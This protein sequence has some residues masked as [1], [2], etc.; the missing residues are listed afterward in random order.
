MARIQVWSTPIASGVRRKPFS[1]Q[2]GL[3]FPAHTAIA[4][5]SN[6]TGALFH[7]PILLAQAKDFLQVR[8][9]Q[10]YYH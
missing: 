3:P 10:A 8:R 9:F 1:N 2:K 7:F 5:L 6:I 4:F